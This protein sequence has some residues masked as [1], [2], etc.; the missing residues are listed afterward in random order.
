[1]VVAH[2]EENSGV[3]RLSPAQPSP[4]SNCSCLISPAHDLV[5]ILALIF[6]LLSHLL[7]LCQLRQHPA[8]DQRATSPLSSAPWHFLRPLLPRSPKPSNRFQIFTE[9]TATS[10]GFWAAALDRANNQNAPSPRIPGPHAMISLR[11]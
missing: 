2:I 11:F 8:L 5:L 7:T 3:F 4:D 10:Q 1:M 6:S 9:Q